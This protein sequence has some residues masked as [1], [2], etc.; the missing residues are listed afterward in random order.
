MGMVM[1]RSSHSKSRAGARVIAAI[2]ATID[3]RLS[4]ECQLIELP[5]QSTIAAMAKVSRETV[6]R[7][8]TSLEKRGVIE[9]EGKSIRIRDRVA[10]CQLASD[11]VAG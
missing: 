5:N 10:L 4:S 9:R 1:E 2:E 11:Y 6:S 3:K 7:V 8:I